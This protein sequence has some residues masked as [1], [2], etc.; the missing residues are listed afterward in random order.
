MWTGLTHDQAETSCS[1]LATRWLRGLTWW[2]D[3]P[4]VDLEPSEFTTPLSH[5]TSTPSSAF[6]QGAPRYDFE[7]LSCERRCGSVR[8]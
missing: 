4:D 8:P 3:L 2:R 7:T 6:R 1:V 5:R